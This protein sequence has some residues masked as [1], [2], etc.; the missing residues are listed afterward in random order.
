MKELLFNY[1][2]EQAKAITFEKILLNFGIS[3]LLAL[4]IYVSYRFA[5]SGPVYSARFNVSLVML[6]LVT[7]LVMTVIG[8]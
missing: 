7:T 8:N 5:H 4:V 1:F 2:Q 3:L 6:T